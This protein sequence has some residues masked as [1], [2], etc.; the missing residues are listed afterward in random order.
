MNS[1]FD[2]RYA[3]QPFPR[4]GPDFWNVKEFP[5]PRGLDG[6]LGYRPMVFA[7]IADG[8]AHRDIWPLSDSKVDRALKK[9]DEIKPYI[10]KWWLAGEEPIQLLINREYAL[11]SAPDGRALAAIKRGISLRMVGRRYYRAKLLDCS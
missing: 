6:G 4:T 9:L 1:L 2:T 3:S 5:G 7:L 10:T 8:V 11:T